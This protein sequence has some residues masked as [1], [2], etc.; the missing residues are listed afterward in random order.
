[1]APHL[2]RP[3]RFVLPLGVG[4]AR[5]LGCCAW[6]CSSM[7]TWAVERSCRRL[8]P[9]ISRAIRSA[10]HSSG[11]HGPGY[12]YSDCWVDDARLVVLNAVDAAERGA[13]IRT[14]TR[15]IGAQRGDVWRFVL[16][17]GR[18]DAPT[19]RVLINATG[20]WLR[21]FAET[22]LRERAPSRMRLVKGSHIVVRR[23]FDHD[24]GYI[25]QA[26]DGRVVFALPFGHDF[27]LIGTTDQTLRAI[28]AASPRARTRSAICARRRTHIFASRSARP[29]SS[30]RL[31][32]CARFTT[33]AR[34]RRRTRRAI[35]CSTSTSAT[36]RIA[37]HLWRQDH[38]L[39]AAGRAGAGPLSAYV[40]HGPGVDQRLALAG[41]RF[42]L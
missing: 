3:M 23:L 34:R 10:H 32:A 11:A 40:A 29:M 14:R 37:Q 13:V 8:A 31:P 28:R 2:I 17:P 39:P 6:D 22:V 7:T 33:T 41:R 27:T 5:G 25:F 16:E 30:G 36:A 20:P 19:A 18:S 21:W 15:C 9:S 35:T 24:R 4:R 12:E 26:G 1:M 38:H 42:S